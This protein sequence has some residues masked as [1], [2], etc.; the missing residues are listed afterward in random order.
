MHILTRGGGGGDKDINITVWGM[1]YRMNRGKM[2]RLHF[3]LH[4]C[5]VPY[6]LERYQ[7]PI[8]T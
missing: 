7:L 1:Q 3:K 6:V 8:V 2:A 5:T 4:N